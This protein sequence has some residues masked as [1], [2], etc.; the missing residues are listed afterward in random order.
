MVS[1][2][3]WTGLDA[4]DPRSS[5]L[6]IFGWVAFWLAIFLPVPLV[7]FVIIGISSLTHLYAF[8]LVFGTNVLALYVGRRHRPNRD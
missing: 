2:R 4:E 7:F 3:K 1:T 5:L 6:G 8:V